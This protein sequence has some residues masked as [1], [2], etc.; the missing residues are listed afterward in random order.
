VHLRERDF[1]FSRFRGAVRGGDEVLGLLVVLLCV[2][3][4][5]PSRRG[6]R[7]RHH[8]GERLSTSGKSSPVGNVLIR[9]G[10]AGSRL[11]AATCPSRAVPSAGGA[12]SRGRSRSGS[13]PRADGRGRFSV[14]PSRGRHELATIIEDDHSVAQQ[15]PALVPVLRDDVSH[16][17]VECL[18]RRALR[19]VLTHDLLPYAVDRRLRTQVCAEGCVTAS[20]P[21]RTGT[22]VVSGVPG[23]RR[24]ERA[25]VNSGQRVSGWARASGDQSGARRNQDPHDRPMKGSDV[26]VEVDA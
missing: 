21:G 25:R 15:A 2:H 26:P 14:R 3:A 11:S 16:A 9:G 1:A 18:A 22:S 6:E 13:K 19:Q 10:R 17:V 5:D 24:G 20:M 7:P 12:A 4:A 23:T 8:E